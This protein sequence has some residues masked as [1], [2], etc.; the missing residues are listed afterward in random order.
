MTV[1]VKDTDLSF[2]YYVFCSATAPSREG[3]R[4]VVRFLWERF[5]HAAFVAP[6][7]PQHEAFASYV[8]KAWDEYLPMVALGATYRRKVRDTSAAG[9]SGLE[10]SDARGMQ[11]M[12]AGSMSGSMHCARRTAWRCTATSDRPDGSRAAGEG[13]PES[14]VAGARSRTASRRASSIW[15]VPGAATGWVTMRGEGSG[16]ESI[17]RCSTMH[18]PVSGCC[19]GRRLRPERKAGDPGVHRPVCAVP[20]DAPA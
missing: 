13:R 6:G 17:F 12:T 15:T 4:D 9:T 14:R 18:G 11:T 20:D 5:G 16:R 10:Q 7:G 2:G 1:A 3:Y 8:Q 19:T